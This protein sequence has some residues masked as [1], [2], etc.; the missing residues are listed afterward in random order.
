MK[1]KEHI[2]SQDNK[3][4]FPDNEPH[5]SKTESKYE[6]YYS[7]ARPEVLALIPLTAKR[8]LDV[9]CGAGGL[10]SGIK[11]RQQTEIHGIELVP[12]QAE[13]AKPHLDRIWNCNVEDALSELPDKNYDCI[14][15]ADVLEHLYDPWTVLTKLKDKLS[16]EGKMVV[17]IPNI[18]N[19]NI[20]FELLQGRWD[21]QSEGILDRTHIRFFTRKSVEELFWNARLCIVNIKATNRSIAIPQNFIKNL[22]KIGLSTNNLQKDNQTYQFLI[23]AS[24]PQPVKVWPKVVIV[25]LIWNGKEDT[26]ECLDSVNQLEYPNFEIVIVDNGSTD[27]SVTVIS[28][29]YPEVSIIQNGENLGYAGGNNIGIKWALN[30]ESE[31]ILILNNDTVV[32]KFMLQNLV[33]TG[34]LDEKIGLL[35]PTNFYYSDPT[36]IW[37][38]GAKLAQPL[39][40]RNQLIG[41][42]DSEKN[43][44]FITQIDSLVGSGMLIR[45]NLFEEIGFFDER[46]FLCH[47]EYDFCMRARN[48]GYKCLHVPKAKIWHKIGKSLGEDASPIRVYF[49]VRN[50]LLWSKKHLSQPALIKLHL[51]NIKILQNILPKLHLTPSKHSFPKRLLW[52]F[53]SWIKAI[54]RNITIPT[55]QAKLMGLRDYYLG[56]FGNCPEQLRNLGKKLDN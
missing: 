10:S 25:I 21:Y 37:T 22:T 56:R 40:L 26:L 16:V 12:E 36:T 33:N 52:S 49:N 48:V 6:Q 44:P 14:I 46:F 18:L 30:K 39:T 29:Q 50:K 54:K 31:Y 15:L 4:F 11:K 8:I 28:N 51:E 24:V 17:S 5:Y 55:N 1:N 41:Q 19:W 47:E 45:K 9:G 23:E 35:G 27:E 42:G 3:F 38:I 34:L 32:D 53:A 20:L 2:A 43:W 7:Y 13:M